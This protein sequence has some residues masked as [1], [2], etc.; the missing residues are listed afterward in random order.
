MVAEKN[1]SRASLG[2]LVATL[3]IFA[4]A[5]VY[6]GRYLFQLQSG[7]RIDG[8]ALAGWDKAVETPTA[9]GKAIATGD[10]RLRW[11]A[12]RALLSA[13]V[14][15]N[16]GGFI[17]LAGGDCIPGVV[18]EYVAAK[19]T[20]AGQIP[21]HLRVRCSSFLASPDA[22]AIEELRVLPAGVT[23]ICFTSRSRRR[24]SPGHVFLRDGSIH[25][26]GRLRWQSTG[27]Q[28]LTADGPQVF[29]FAVIEE[30]HLPLDTETHNRLVL[31]QVESAGERFII[32][33]RDGLVATAPASTFHAVGHSHDADRVRKLDQVGRM[34]SRIEDLKKRIVKVTDTHESRTA[35]H[36]RRI[37]EAGRR[38]EA[39]LKR[40]ANSRQQHTPQK[41]KQLEEAAKREHSTAVKKLHA[42]AERYEKMHVRHLENYRRQ[43]EHLQ[44]LVD[45]HH[46]TW[47]ADV[48]T[49]DPTTWRHQV[50][51]AWSLDPVW[52]KFTDIVSR[53]TLMP[54]ELPLTSLRPVEV[55]QKSTFGKGLPWRTNQS[56][57]QTP[58]RSAGASHAWGLGTHA[59]CELH[60]ELPGNAMQFQASVALDDAAGRGGCARAAV[61]LNRSDGKPL[62]ESPLLYGERKIHSSGR[63]QLPTAA[64]AR[65][66]ILVTSQAG[67][68]RPQG[69]AP[70][71]IQDHVN[72]LEPVLKLAP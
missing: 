24:F 48:E 26:F 33:C 59:Q 15:G 43:I 34:E 56:V 12:N 25:S 54:D 57:L 71:D 38:A 30:L 55:I 32:K 58:L 65:R 1:I 20:D 5:P 39:A 14:Q 21:A 16:P 64:N 4:T 42:S 35:A 10:D 40:I 2:L 44:G 19:D 66:L 72:W 27:A 23:R 17:E 61:Y 53:L 41:K 9:D 31:Q 67:A 37:S 47:D 6:A 46:R 7:E 49:R 18:L 51:P 60:Y 13:G 69:A 28:L 11:Y 52:I 22:G 68:D 8:A 62:Y 36:K 63:L 70:F 3:L 45:E 29:A 50:H